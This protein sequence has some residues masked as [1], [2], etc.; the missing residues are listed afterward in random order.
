M[1]ISCSYN[2]CFFSFAILSNSFLRLTLY[3]FCLVKIKK[4]ELRFVI[5]FKGNN[6]FVQKMNQ[7]PIVNLIACSR[8]FIC[9]YLGQTLSNK[10]YDFVRKSNTNCS[11]SEPCGRKNVDHKITNFTLKLGE[12]ERDKEMVFVP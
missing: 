10:L 2:V 11:R 1:E 6:F 12:K 8:T 5:F 9:L 4:N 3:I 7:S